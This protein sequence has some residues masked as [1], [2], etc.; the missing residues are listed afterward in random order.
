MKTEKKTKNKR[1]ADLPEKLNLRSHDMA[2]DKE[3]E[4]L[5]LFPEVRTEGGKIDFERLKLALGEAVDVGKERYGMNWPGKA[6]CFKAIQSPSMGTLRPC[7][8]E[9]VEFDTT[10]NLIIEGDNL[11]VLKLLQKSYLGKVKMIYI[12]PPYNTGNDFIYPDNYSESLQTY[13]QYTGQ[14]DDEGK[15]FGTNTDADGRFHSKWLNMLYPRLYLARNLLAENGSIFITIDDS[16]ITNL[17][18]VCDEL[19][20]EENFIACVSWQKKY[21]VS[22]NHKGVASVRDFIVVYARS[23]HFQNGLLPR[24]KEATAR[25]I[26]PDNDPRGPWKPVD[27]WNVASPEDRPNL[28]YEISNPTTRKAITPTKKA[29]KFSKEAHERHVNENR[30]WWGSDGKNSVPALKLF[31]ADV[32]AGL[33]PHNWWPH[34]DAGHTDEAKKELDRLFGGNAPFDTPKPVRLIERMCQVGAVGPDDLVLDFFAG[35]STTAHAILKLNN[36]DRGNRRFIMVQLPEPTDRP[37]YPTIAEITKERVRRSIKVLRKKDEGT[38][39]FE[40]RDRQDL[41]FRVYKL[42]ESNF[43]PW[44]AEVPH[45]GKAL[46]DQLELHV[47]HIRKGSSAE[48]I[49]SEILLKSGFPLTTPVETLKLEG[50]TVYSIADGALLICLDRKLT[51]DL[52]R[53]M[54]EKKPER[55]V[56]LDEGFAGNDQL[57]TNAVQTF[58]TKGVTSFKTV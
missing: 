47:N 14:V 8:Q 5:Q 1:A 17:R 33:I 34:E 18:R 2:G 41:G 56:C 19:F 3:R 9:S 11:E 7:P 51:L 28:V 46:E 29:W 30:I 24:T 38:L 22:N 27:Y 23:S 20:G 26:N 53:A 10:E 13:L 39:D 40:K 45:N 42:T 4:L 49:L 54:A 35:S 31:L 32:K 55:V 50:K 6:D 44:N 12:D 57:K 43:K 36:E 15:K 37:G 21:S 48:D 58:R 25:Y 52:I 16:E